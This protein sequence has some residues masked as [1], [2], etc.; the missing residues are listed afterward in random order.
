VFFENL[1]IKSKFN[2]N[3]TRKMSTLHEDLYKFFIISRS[4]LFRM[5]NV[6]DKS[7]RENKRTHFVFSNFFS[8]NRADCEKMWQNIVERGRPQM[9]VWRMRIAFW[10][11]K[12]THTH[13]EYVIRIAFPQQQRFNELASMLHYTHVACLVTVNSCS[14]YW[15]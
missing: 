14:Q 9:A 15:N 2:Y 8:E 1:S 5:R 3:R 7:C 4:V 11:P 12:A 10:I 6:S 13:S